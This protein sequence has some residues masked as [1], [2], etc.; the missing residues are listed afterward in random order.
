[1]AQHRKLNWPGS[2]VWM[3]RGLLQYYFYLWMPTL[4]CSSLSPRVCPCTSSPCLPL[5]QLENLGRKWQGI[6]QWT[7]HLSFLSLPGVLFPSYSTPG[8]IRLVGTATQI[9]LFIFFNSSVQTQQWK[10][11][12]E[13]VTGI[14]CM[15]LKQPPK[16]NSHVYTLA[17]ILR[18][19]WIAFISP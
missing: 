15:S 17:A 14:Q 5:G 3:A 19:T 4:F 11:Q 13:G 12:R 7:G 8:C 9:C 6:G 10:E 18:K 1:M 2:K 16:G